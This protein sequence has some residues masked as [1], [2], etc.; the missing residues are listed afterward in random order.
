MSGISKLSFV[1]KNQIQHV[2]LLVAIYFGAVYLADLDSS[3]GSLLGISSAT[4]F[5]VTIL[6]AV[7]HQF[8]VWFAFRFQLVYKLLTRLFGKYDLTIWAILFLPFLVL[9]PILTL[10]AGISDFQSLYKVN[11][12][13]FISGG[14]LLIP[15]A[16]TLYSVFRYF[17]LK[18]AIG[19]DHFRVKYRNL[20][21]VRKGMFKYSPDAMYLFAFLLFWAIGIITGSRIALSLAVFQHAY[22]WVHMFC[23]EEP[24]MQKIYEE[25]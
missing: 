1:F 22:I 6:N 11:F 13:S 4:W 16:Y 12:I 7:V 10:L 8:L 18:R 25:V 5:Y 2:L 17:G 21:L 3:G 24:D 19:G 15:V 23:T 14:L 9:R 20:P